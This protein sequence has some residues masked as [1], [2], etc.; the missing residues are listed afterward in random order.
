LACERC[1]LKPTGLAGQTSSLQGFPVL[2]TCKADLHASAEAAI[3]GNQKAVG[4]V[5]DVPYPRKVRAAMTS[6]AMWKRLLAAASS[7]TLG[8]FML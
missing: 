8:E 6:A 1:F 5:A 4:L 2:A 7:M 3:P